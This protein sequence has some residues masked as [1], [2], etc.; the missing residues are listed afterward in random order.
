[1]EPRWASKSTGSE[2]WTRKSRA[3]LS[4]KEM[5][6]MDT[7]DGKIMFSILL[8][9]GINIKKHKK[10]DRQMDQMAGRRSWLKMAVTWDC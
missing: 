9:F 2:D 4:G 6:R 10:H 8:C 5:K 3:G 7:N 1:M